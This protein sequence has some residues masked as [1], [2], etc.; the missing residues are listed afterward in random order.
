MAR[1]GD[2]FVYIVASPGRTIYIRVTNNLERRMWEHRQRSD[3][4]FTARYNVTRLVW[5]E[6]FSRIDD[7]IAR[8]KQLKGWGR[9]KKVALVEAVNPNWADLSSGWDL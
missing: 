6:M 8:E 7:A 4:G 5:F 3:G 9:A 1:V 2:F